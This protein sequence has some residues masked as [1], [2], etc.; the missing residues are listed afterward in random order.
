LAQF[1]RIG[2]SMTDAIITIM[3][4]V[5][6]VTRVEPSQT[7]IA[8]A[9]K[10]YFIL[11]EVGNQIKY[12]LK[13]AAQTDSR[14]KIGIKEPFWRYDMLAGPGKNILARAGFFDRCLQEAIETTREF[15]QKSTGTKPSLD[16]VAKSLKSS[17]IL[18]EIKNQIQW[19]RKN[20]RQ[21]KKRAVK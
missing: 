5:R 21:A 18:S 17:F 6:T 14:E 8:E 13:K 1:I 19:Q 4:Y 2:D 7:E 10:S 20:A 16:I 9:L 3:K 15:M 12:Q 11:N